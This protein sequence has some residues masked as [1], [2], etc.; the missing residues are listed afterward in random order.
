MI[1]LEGQIESIATRKDR[2]LSIRI[3]TQEQPPE[4]VGQ[5]MSL[6]QKFSFLAIKEDAITNKELEAMDEVR[7]EYSH[8]KTHSQRLKSVLYLNWGQKNE[9]FNT[10]Q[11]YYEHHM[12]RMI[13]HFKGKIDG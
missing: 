1:I 7:T 6:N 2:T 12:E 4:K 10:F 11:S 13:E 9:G 3:G 8:A 5:L